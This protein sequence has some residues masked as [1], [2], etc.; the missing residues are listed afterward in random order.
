[1]SASRDTHAAPERR[2]RAPSP[3]SPGLVFLGLLLGLLVVHL[4]TRGGREHADRVNVDG[5]EPALAPGWVASVALEPGAL[6]PGEL[7]AR[8]T[9][10]HVAP[11]RQSFDADALRRRLALGPGEPWRLELWLESDAEPP[12]SVRLGSIAV[13]DAAGT[14]LVPAVASAQTRAGATEAGGVADPLRTLAAV[15][16]VL[17]AGAPRQVLLWG[18]A[19]QDEPQLVLGALAAPVPLEPRDV[20]HDALPQSLARLP[21]PRART[22]AR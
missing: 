6:G 16:P 10:L 12:A 9:R 17:R 1:M 7:R 8:L 2:R 11:E 5:S 3:R 22:S 15:D 21:D 4:L 14:A 19:P 13:A 18:R 20:E